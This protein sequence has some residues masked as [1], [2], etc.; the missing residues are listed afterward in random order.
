MTKHRNRP[1]IPLPQSWPLHVKPALLHVI[2]VAQ[3][4]IAYTRGW[5]VNSPIAQIRLKAENERLKQHLAL[6]VP[7]YAIRAE[8]GVPSGELADMPAGVNGGHSRNIRRIG[9]EVAR[10]R[11]C[12]RT[13][14]S[15]G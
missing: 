3:H 7:E 8:T 13:S 10:L 11:G 15:D 6:V 14:T 2:A 9:A 12:E 5:A 4:A 1:K